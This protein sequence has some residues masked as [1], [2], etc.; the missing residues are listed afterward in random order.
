MAIDDDITNDD[1]YLTKD[2]QERFRKEWNK[3]TTELKK[4][5]YDL[6]KIKITK[7]TKSR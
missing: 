6:D 1:I 5:D 7:I 3:T 4:S 2:E